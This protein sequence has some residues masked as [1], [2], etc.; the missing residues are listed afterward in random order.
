MWSPGKKNKKGP[1]TR[2]CLL[3]MNSET[4][5]PP[6]VLEYAPI[7]YQVTESLGSLI[8]LTI[9]LGHENIYLKVTCLYVCSFHIAL[10]GY[11]GRTVTGA[12]P[13]TGLKSVSVCSKIFP[14]GFFTQVSI[15]HIAWGTETSRKSFH[16]S[17]YLFTSRLPFMKTHCRHFW[18]VGTGKNTNASFVSYTGSPPGVLEE[19]RCVFPVHFFLSTLSVTIAWIHFKCKLVFVHPRKMLKKKSVHVYQSVL[20]DSASEKNMYFVRCLCHAVN[21]RDG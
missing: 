17:P 16:I 20:C 21:G 9:L 11:N 19:S 18:A 4:G 13:S 8:C 2:E 7:C 3:H 10:C 15:P 6:S 1:E 14:E 12:Q 5:A